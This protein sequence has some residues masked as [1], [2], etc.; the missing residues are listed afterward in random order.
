MFLLERAT[1]ASHM[2]SHQ[3]RL[4]A[5]Y[6]QFHLRDEAA[7]GD[8]S[9][10]WSQAAVERMLAVS[11]GVVG[12]GTVRDM[13]VPVTIEFLEA[14]PAVDLASFDHVVEGSLVVSRGPLLVAGCTDPL[15]DAA[16]FDLKPG[17]YRVRLSASGFDTLSD[18]GLD[19]ED[20]YLVQLWQAPLIESTVLKQGVV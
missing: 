11:D 9:D 1:P 7:G 5:D 13:D 10:A 19:G 12:I 20:R 2:Q 8:L 17:T 18:D 3:L 16:R 6:H 15:P 4:F 14:E